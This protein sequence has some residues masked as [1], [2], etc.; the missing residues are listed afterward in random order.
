VFCAAHVDQRNSDKTRARRHMQIATDA[1]TTECPHAACQ[2]CVTFDIDQAGHVEGG[3]EAQVL[4]AVQEPTEG[5]VA[6]ARHGEAAPDVGVPRSDVVAIDA[7]VASQQLGGIRA[8]TGAKATRAEIAG[9]A[10]VFAAAQR[11]RERLGGDF[12]GARAGHW[13]LLLGH[14]AI[15]IT[16]GALAVRARGVCRRPIRIRGDDGRNVPGASAA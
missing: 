10:R 13:D 7:Y 14:Q 5:D 1:H 4:T 16:Q 12:G 8:V 2:K 15:G 3:I 11:R 9:D 6:F